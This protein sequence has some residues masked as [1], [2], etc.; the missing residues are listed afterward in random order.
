PDSSRNSTATRGRDPGRADLT[1]AHHGRRP[2]PPRRLARRSG[3]VPM[4]G[5]SPPQ[6]GGG[7]G[8]VH[9]QEATRGGA[10]RHRGRGAGR[11]LPPV[12]AGNGDIGWDRPVPG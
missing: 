6:P 9:G 1:A 4:V 11:W 3:G 8:P 10:L 5:G 12:L 7:G 2:R